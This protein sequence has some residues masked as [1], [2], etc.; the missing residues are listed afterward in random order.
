MP[1]DFTQGSGFRICGAVLR[2]F[3]AQSGK[4]AF[5]TV[6]VARARSSVKFDMRTFSRSLIGEIE[7]LGAGQVVEVTGAVDVEPVKDRAGKEVSIDGYS[8][9]VP[10]LT[11]KVLRVLGGAASGPPPDAD[12]AP[13]EDDVPF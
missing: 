4:V 7:E 2:K 1:G 11:M 5:L 13:P 6:E 12:P 9:W 3:V 10:A 8:K